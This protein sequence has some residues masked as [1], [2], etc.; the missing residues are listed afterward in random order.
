MTV[1]N[2]TDCIMVFSCSAGCHRSMEP[3]CLLQSASC[4]I[5]TSTIKHMSLQLQLQKTSSGRAMVEIKM[6]IL[7]L[8]GSWRPLFRSTFFIPCP[9]AIF[10]SSYTGV[11]Y[12]PRRNKFRPSQIGTPPPPPNAPLTILGHETVN[13]RVLQSV[14]LQPRM[15]RV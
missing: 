9:I 13:F 11:Y 2:S 15:Q 7:E 10:I 14:I 5:S 6:V 8:F 1:R 4:T 3:M 12:H